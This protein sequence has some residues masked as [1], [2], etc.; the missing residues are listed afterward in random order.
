MGEQINELADQQKQTEYG[1]VSVRDGVDVSIERTGSEP[2]NVGA[3]ALTDQP[4]PLEQ[5]ASA[6]V[7]DVEP[8]QAIRE[9]EETPSPG[10][11]VAKSFIDDVQAASDEKL[12]DGQEYTIP[13]AKP[14]DEMVL[15][16]EG[17]S[18]RFGTTGA[19]VRMDYTYH[20]RRDASDGEIVCGYKSEPME[21]VASVNTEQHVTCPDCLAAISND[22]FNATADDEIDRTAE[23]V[24][25]IMEAHEVVGSRTM[26]FTAR[27]N[28][29]AGST[30]SIE[31]SR[32]GKLILGFE[33]NYFDLSPAE[34]SLLNE[35]TER[36]QRYPEHPTGDRIISDVDPSQ[37]I[38]L[39]KKKGWFGRG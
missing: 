23:I 37:S 26:N 34:R 27:L 36:F 8:A 13:P 20:L 16:F 35:L 31:F 14:V 19:P 33:G 28:V 24:E 25:T 3:E 22:P 12:I 30:T 15:P 21:A 18:Q 2:T 7:E 38:E 1:F 32:G 5:I 39:P 17:V 29:V 9:P 4:E 6:N 11:D 10:D